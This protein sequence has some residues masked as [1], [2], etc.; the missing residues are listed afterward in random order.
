MNIDIGTHRIKFRAIGRSPRSRLVR[1]SALWLAFNAAERNTLSGS[2]AQRAKALINTLG[3]V[4]EIPAP[5]VMNLLQDLEDNGLIA[6]GR[7]AEIANAL[8]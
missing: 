5:A 4:A 6:A 8:R 3:I 1:S 2:A 7:A